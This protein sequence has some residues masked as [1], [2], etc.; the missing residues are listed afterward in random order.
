M[1]VFQL[2]LWALLFPTHFFHDKRA[3]PVLLTGALE[4][5]SMVAISIAMPITI[6]GNICV[7]LWCEAELLGK[8]TK[9]VF[10]PC[11]YKRV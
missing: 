10:Y 3:S 8:Y 6:S 11:F 5:L 9:L 1:I 4:L 7:K 2:K